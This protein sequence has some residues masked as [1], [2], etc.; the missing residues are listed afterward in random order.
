MSDPILNGLSAVDPL[1]FTLDEPE[2]SDRLVV[3]F[4]R[5]VLPPERCS[6]PEEWERSWAA[7]VAHK[8]SK[9]LNPDGTPM[10]KDPDAEPPMR[11]IQ[12]GRRVAPEDLPD[13]PRRLLAQ[14]IERGWKAVPQLSVTQHDEVLFVA[15]SEEGA[16]KP[17]NSGDVRYEAKT[18]EHFGIQGYYGEAGRFWATWD[19]TTQI[20]K[21][22]QTK[23][24]GALTYDPISG[25]IF[26]KRVMDFDE[27]R[28]IIDGSA[29]EAAPEV[30]EW[31]RGEWHE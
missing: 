23:F 9:G 1:F 5:T 16:E 14:L 22:V 25:S 2:E 26:E 30:P 4:E 31:E 3:K 8:R 19:R 21:K 24:I 27:W 11:V 13:A 12:E 6:P 18:V 17:H 15:T 7:L 28:G 10:V 20:G 29:E